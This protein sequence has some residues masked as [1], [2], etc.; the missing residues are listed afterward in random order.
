M[1]VK[2]SMARGYWGVRVLGLQLFGR[3]QLIITL[4]IDRQ[5]DHVNII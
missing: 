3:V 4:Q 5:I 2:E 1:V